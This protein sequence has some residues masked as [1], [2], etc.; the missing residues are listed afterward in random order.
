MWGSN[1]IPP[2]EIRHFQTGTQKLL[3]SA[4]DLC[5]VD[6]RDLRDIEATHDYGL[7]IKKFGGKAKGVDDIEAVWQYVRKV[8]EI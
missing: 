7:G 1:F 2:S 8:M 6:V 3:N 5:P 4:S